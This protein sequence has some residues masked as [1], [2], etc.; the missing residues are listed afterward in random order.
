MVDYSRLTPPLVKAVQELSKEND[1]LK[2]A[3][4]TLTKRLELLEQK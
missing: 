1:D 4:E 2:K 3:I